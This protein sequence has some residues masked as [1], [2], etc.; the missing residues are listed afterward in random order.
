MLYIWNAGLAST[1][2]FPAKITGHISNLSVEAAQSTPSRKE[3]LFINSVLLI[4]VVS[5]VS[6]IALHAQDHKLAIYFSFGFEMGH[7]MLCCIVFAVMSCAMG[8]LI[9][10]FLA[11]FLDY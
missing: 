11:F 4:C 5:L 2:P 3:W 10:K 9:T 1:D 7:T 8:K 6:P